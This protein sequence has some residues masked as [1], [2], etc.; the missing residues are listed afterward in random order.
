MQFF[1]I[2]YLFA[3]Y[4][5]AICVNIKVPSYRTYKYEYTVY[6]HIIFF[7]STIRDMPILYN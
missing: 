5:F 6:K 7:L 3:I 2:S 4:I 1:N